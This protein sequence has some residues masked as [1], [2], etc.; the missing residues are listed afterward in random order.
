MPRRGVP[1]G[2]RTSGWGGRSAAQLS[3]REAG[4]PL[5]RPR[6]CSRDEPVSRR[7]EPRPH[8]RATRASQTSIKRCP[9]AS[10]L[11]HSAPIFR[12]SRHDSRAVSSLKREPPR[13][14]IRLERG[15]SLAAAGTSGYSRNPNPQHHCASRTISSIVGPEQSCVLP[16]RARAAYFTLALAFMRV[17]RHN[18]NS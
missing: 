8:R 18:R 13:S 2:G 9:R 12:P 14:K 17:P 5:C 3:P 10:A 4:R 11:W 7:R 16:M 15:G 1:P 6:C